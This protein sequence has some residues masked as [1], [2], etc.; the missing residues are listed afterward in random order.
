MVALGEVVGMPHPARD[1]GVAFLLG[2]AI[3]ETVPRP[4]GKGALLCS[5]DGSLDCQALRV[6]QSWPEGNPSPVRM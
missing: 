2:S 5:W 3:P 4:P 1:P 6:K